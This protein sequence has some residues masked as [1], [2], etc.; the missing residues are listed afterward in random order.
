M[1]TRGKR[2]HH[3]LSRDILLGSYFSSLTIGFRESAKE[4]SS[5]TT[6]SG[7]CYCIVEL[8]NTELRV[9]IIIALAL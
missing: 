8:L 1:A 7:E 6:G 5:V 2:T 3:L 4:S 9:G